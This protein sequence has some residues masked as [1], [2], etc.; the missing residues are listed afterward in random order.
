MIRTQHAFPLQ[1]SL[2]VV[3]HMVEQVLGEVIWMHADETLHVATASHTREELVTAGPEFYI[4]GLLPIFIVNGFIEGRQEAALAKTAVQSQYLFARCHPSTLLGDKIG[5]TAGRS[6]HLAKCTFPAAPVPSDELFLI[7]TF[8]GTQ[9][10]DGPVKLGPRRWARG[11]FSQCECLD[12]GLP[13]Y[14]VLRL[15]R[16]G[17]LDVRFHVDVTADGRVDMHLLLIA[18]SS[19]HII[20]VVIQRYRIQMLL[21]TVFRF[22]EQ[23]LDT[24]KS[25]NQPI[26]L[27]TRHVT[28]EL[29][30]L[31]IVHVIVD[32]DL[33]CPQP[34]LLQLLRHLQKVLHV[35]AGDPHVILKHNEGVVVID[36]VLDDVSVLS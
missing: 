20:E 34:H 36:L 17:C 22:I 2:F 1:L 32:G 8:A 27:I 10:D 3:G 4:H 14:H 7:K 29:H 25:R 35:M 12:V 16:L 31:R 28:K 5:R 11:Q 30:A 19:Q 23:H 15:G 26:H 24:H 9:H 33:R 13:Y 18:T 6:I 21:R